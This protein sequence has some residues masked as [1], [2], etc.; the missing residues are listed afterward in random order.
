MDV[1]RRART[2]PFP[3]LLPVTVGVAALVP[4]RG[5]ASGVVD[6]ATTVAIGLLFFLYGARLST[7]EAVHGLR[8]WRLHTTVLA[9]T[10][11]VFPLLGLAVALLPERLLPVPLA[12]GVLFLCCLPS[13]VQSSIAFTSLARGNVPAAVVA[14]SLSNVLGVVVTPLLAALLLSTRGGFS[15]ASLLDI[16]L[17][18]L[19]PFVAGQLARPLIGRWVLA[20][21]ARL[22]VVD[23]GS[24]L[25]VVY[26]AFGA[27]MVAGV[28]RE[29]TGPSLV[30]LLAVEVVLLAVVL[31]LTW[32]GARGLGFDPGDRTTILFCGSKKSL[33]SGLPMAGVLFA[34]HAVALVVLPVMLFHQIQLMV[35]AAIAARLA[36]RREVSRAEPVAAS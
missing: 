21:R 19:A 18:L 32:W 35:C 20:H 24:I 17:R 23:R 3:V 15:A 22:L 16:G 26:S 7:R 13:T 9:A 29:L 6:A 12:T 28:W 2:D 36:R 8:H 11:V 10:F 31:A 4:A 34:G 30:V 25:L 33:S 1:L 27:G 5:A 14:A